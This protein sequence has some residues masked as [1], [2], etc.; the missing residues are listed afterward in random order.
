MI[1]ILLK[2]DYN[3]VIYYYYY[4]YINIS[5][6]R[7]MNTKLFSKIILQ[8]VV[9]NLFSFI[10]FE[11]YAQFY[12]I[13]KRY[14]D[15]CKK[16]I[17]PKI[18]KINENNI[19]IV[20]LFNNVKFSLYSNFDLIDKSNDISKLFDLSKFS[21]LYE[22]T[23][24]GYYFITDVS[25]LKNIKIVTLKYCEYLTD[26]SPLKNVQRLTIQYNE[27]LTDI[28]SLSNVKYLDLSWCINISNVSALKN[29]KYLF[30]SGCRSVTDITKLNNVKYLDIKMCHN[31]PRYQIDIMSKKINNICY[32]SY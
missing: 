1:T 27:R 3:F 20:N 16:Y 24:F 32:S 30:L 19:K 9:W 7:I 29:V 17:Y 23:L 8:N 11:T 28:S 22:V 31:I 6:R 2:N 15:L 4:Y 14:R 12:F 21:N 5:T 10:P 26:V 18:V 25:A 13:S